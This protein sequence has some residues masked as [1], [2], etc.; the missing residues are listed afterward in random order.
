[1]SNSEPHPFGLYVNARGFIDAGTTLHD[2]M[3]GNGHL[4]F[5]SMVSHLFGLEL[6]L[7]C[8]YLIRNRK[9][10]KGH[11]LKDLFE[12]LPL[13]DRSRIT[14][15][16]N[17]LENVELVNRFFDQKGIPMTRSLEKDLDT[18]NNQYASVRYWWEGNFLND[19]SEEAAS[20][21]LRA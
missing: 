21:G 6:L 11:K 7:K 8:L 4:G 14:Q 1:M 12:A 18:L 13:E 20:G 10:I 16:F 19:E 9:R 17:N 5:P 15:L 3:L 2:N